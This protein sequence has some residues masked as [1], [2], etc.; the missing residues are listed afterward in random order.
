MTVKEFLESV[1]NQTVI[2][3]NKETNFASAMKNS[4]TNTVPEMQQTI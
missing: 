2:D 1:D 4:V 3:F